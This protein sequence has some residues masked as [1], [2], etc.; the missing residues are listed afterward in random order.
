MNT[1]VDKGESKSLRTTATLSRLWLHILEVYHMP[2]L[3]TLKMHTLTYVI[4]LM[5]RSELETKWERGEELKLLGEAQGSVGTLGP[6]TLPPFEAPHAVLTGEVTIMVHHEKN[7]ALHA[8]VW[9][10]ALV[11]RTVHVQVVVDTHGHRVF[12]LPE[13]ATE[14]QRIRSGW[15][16]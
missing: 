13:P 14:S 9:L 15:L 10:G 4:V 3:N 11:V 12:A 8:A 2:L 7:V 16:T 6:V 5:P 1:V